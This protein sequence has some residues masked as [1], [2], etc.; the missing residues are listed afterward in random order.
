MGP[1]VALRATGSTRR[2]RVSGIGQPDD[3]LVGGLACCHFTSR[4]AFHPLGSMIKD[5]YR[6]CKLDGGFYIGPGE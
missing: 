4:G 2:R 6:Q 5:R 1:P 3:V